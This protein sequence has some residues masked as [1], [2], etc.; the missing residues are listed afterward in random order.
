[1]QYDL[2]KKR[3][4]KNHKIHLIIPKLYYNLRYKKSQIVLK[5]ILDDFFNK[6]AYKIS[7]MNRFSRA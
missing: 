1:L 4:A 7:W 2:P 6:D 5:D 3:N